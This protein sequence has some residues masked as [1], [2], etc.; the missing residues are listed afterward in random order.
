MNEQLLME[1]WKEYSD[2]G[3]DYHNRPSMFDFFKAG[4]DACN[5]QNK[6]IKEFIEKGDYCEGIE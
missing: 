5:R 2:K 6:E 3:W 1:A 4:W